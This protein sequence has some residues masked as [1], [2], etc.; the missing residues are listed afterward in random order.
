MDDIVKI[1]KDFPK[2]FYKKVDK[3]GEYVMNEDGTHVMVK[4]KLDT[5]ELTEL[6][7]DHFKNRLRHDLLKLRIE[8]D[9]EPI[10]N[11]LIGHFYILLSQLGYY[12]SDKF[13]QDGLLW[14]AQ[15]NNF[16]PIVEFLENI[17]NDDSIEPADINKISTN[18]LETDDP[19]SDQMMKCTLVGMIARVINRGCKFDTCLVLKGDQGIGKS[20]FWRILAGQDWFCDSWNENLKDLYLTIQTCWIFELAELDNITTKKDAGAIKCLLSSASDYFRRPYERVTDIHP[21]PSIFVGTCNTA[22]FLTDPSGSR[23][24]QIIDLGNKMID[25]DTVK[26]DRLKILKAAV[27]AFRNGEKTYLSSAD[28]NKSNLNNLAYQQEHPFMSALYNWTEREAQ[29]AMFAD[30]FTTRMALIRSDVRSENKITTADCRAGADCLRQ[31]GYE[32]SINQIKT[33]NGLKRLWKKNTN[34]D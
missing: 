3:K 34:L 26:E 31:L 32:Q 11:S 20:S 18:Y 16:H 1:A 24:F 23:R 33:S 5:G 10:D 4:K 2:G 22:H 30:G 6:L 25:L 8:L 28:Q 29:T 19:L 17:E 27:I 15:K 9:N 12:V 13:A 14:V 7:L 21:R